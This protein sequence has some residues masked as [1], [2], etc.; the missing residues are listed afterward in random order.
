MEGSE[1]VTLPGEQS[2]SNLGCDKVLDDGFLKLGEN[3]NLHPVLILQR[4]VMHHIG[5][6]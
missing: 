5:L 1:G 2:L 3:R 4:D 6:V